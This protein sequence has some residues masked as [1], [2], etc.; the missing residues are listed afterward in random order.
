MLAEKSI[1]DVWNNGNC[2][3]IARAETHLVTNLKQY[4]KYVKTQTD[5]KEFI[6]HLVSSYNKKHAKRTF[7]RENQEFGDD[8]GVCNLN[9]FS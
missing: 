4:L 5:S 9:L 3:C 8:L 2:A 1:T 6:L 7:K